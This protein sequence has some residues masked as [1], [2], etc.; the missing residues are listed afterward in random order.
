MIRKV[1][2]IFTLSMGAPHLWAAQTEV[3]FKLGTDTVGQ[4]LMNFCHFLKKVAVVGGVE[5]LQLRAQ[6][7]PPCRSTLLWW[8]FPSHLW[9][10][11]EQMV[12]PELENARL[13]GGC[14]TTVTSK[15]RAQG[16][17]LSF[18]QNQSHKNTLQAY[19]VF[20]FW[21]GR[22]QNPL[23]QC[24]TRQFPGKSHFKPFHAPTAPQCQPRHCPAL[25]P[26]P[27]EPLFTQ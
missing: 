13:A 8:V 3:L 23:C 6:A 25:L 10:N 20:C 19:D 14:W 27:M 18:T 22:L 24:E 9:N 21:W 2:L 26:H 17:G 16:K 12:T 5:V 7:S 4:Q 1:F 15:R 11:Q